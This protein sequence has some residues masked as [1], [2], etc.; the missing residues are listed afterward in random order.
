MPNYSHVFEGITDPRCRNATRHDLHEMLMMALLTVLTGAETMYRHGSI[1]PRKESFSSS[2]HDPD[3]A[4]PALR[5]SL[6]SS[7]A[8]TPRNLAVP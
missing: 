5:P 4:S 1:W 7:I 3:M 2:F 8:S 6:I